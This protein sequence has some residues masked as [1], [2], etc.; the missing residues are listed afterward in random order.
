MATP[1]ACGHSQARGQIG[2][3]AAATTTA[4]VDLSYI[5]DLCGSLWQHRIPDP[6]REAHT[7]TEATRV[8]NLLSHNG[9][10]YIVFACFY[11]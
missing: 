6:L 5:C 3:A 7:L 9:N 11:L 2:A 10:S 1:M 8:L 4:A